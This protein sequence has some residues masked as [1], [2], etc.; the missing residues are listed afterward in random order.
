MPTPSAERL[1][2]TFAPGDIEEQILVAFREGLR[3]LVDPESG[4]PF[5]EETIRQVTLEGGRFQVEA[6][7]WDQVAQAIQRRDEFLA[8]QVDPRRATATFLDGFHSQRVNLPRLGATGG[9]GFV[10][11]NGIP[12]T[13]YVGSTTV[14]DLLAQ[15]AQ[16]ANGLRYQ[17]FIG[18]KIQTTPTPLTSVQ[19]LLVGV[20]TGPAT[21]IKA[22]TVLTWI[23]PPQGSEPTCT[24][25]AGGDFAGGLPVETDAEWGERIFSAMGVK[26][27]SGNPAE[28]RMWARRASNGVKNAYVYPCAL[29]AGSF[30]VAL[31][32]KRTSPGKL[33]RTLLLTTQVVVGGFLTPPTSPKVPGRVHGVVT[34]FT[35]QSSDGVL[36]LSMRK[37]SVAGWADSVP[38]PGFAGTP[39][40]VQATGPQT[41]TNFR[42]N[43]S[44]APPAGVIPQVMIWDTVLSKFERL[45]VQSVTAAGGGLYDILLTSAAATTI[46]TGVRV[47]PDSARRIEL[48]QAIEKYFDSLGPGE[49][50][51]LATDPRAP[52]AFRRPRPEQE[53]TYQAGVDI[54]EF[55]RQALGGALAHGVIHTLS[56]T[57]PSIPATASTG[58]NMLV[59]NQIAVYPL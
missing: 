16:D 15:Q 55:F 18:G 40:T 9:S 31:T 19:L 1:F 21:N 26:P 12:G 48:G 58:P 47:S 22:G 56:P 46:A 38:W 29:H 14:P 30:V 33:G 6:R 36:Q 3:A 13:T 42:I 49:L 43:S 24:V 34:G 39:S 27:G 54:I 51:D 23:N 50:V 17:V 5:T 4:Q 57:T 10:T 28:L 2:T 8:Q 59:P 25:T 20:D 35:P 53:D 41:Q 32:Q 45:N 7:S 44:T 37:G 11:A 52:R